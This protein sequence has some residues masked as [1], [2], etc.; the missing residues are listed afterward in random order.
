LSFDFPLRFLSVFR[1]GEKT[2]IFPC[3][4]VVPGLDRVPTFSFFLPRPGL[5]F[6][7]T[8]AVVDWEVLFSGVPS[9]GLG[10]FDFPNPRFSFSVLFAISLLVALVLALSNQG[11]LANPI[12]RYRF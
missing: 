7:V 8:A 6:Y 11:V 1:I 4:V 9:G 2:L 12:T 3:L 5:E 10:L